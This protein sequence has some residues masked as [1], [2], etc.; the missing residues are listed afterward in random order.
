MPTLIQVQEHQDF[1][2]ENNDASLVEQAFPFCQSDLGDVT[3]I[4][5]ATSI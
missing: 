3:V 5:I 2:R 4:R 1:L